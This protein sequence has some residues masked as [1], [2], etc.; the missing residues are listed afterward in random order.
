MFLTD[1]SVWRSYC[2]ARLAELSHTDDDFDALAVAL[3]NHPI[4]GAMEPIEAAELYLSSPAGRP[5]AAA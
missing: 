3:E 5:A 1:A 2:A 4:Y